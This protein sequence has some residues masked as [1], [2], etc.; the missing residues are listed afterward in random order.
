[1]DSRKNIR[2]SS[3]KDKSSKTIKE[4]EIAVETIRKENKIECIRFPHLST[5]H[6][7][8]KITKEN[9]KS[10]DKTSKCSRI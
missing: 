6:W 4:G 7:I 8:T 1:M 3:S 9:F 2:Q 5:E 10:N